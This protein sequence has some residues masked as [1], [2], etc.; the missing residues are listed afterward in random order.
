[1]DHN[2]ISDTI[3]QSMTPV[4]QF[5]DE[6]PSAMYV[7][8]FPCSSFRNEEPSLFH[9]L[10]YDKCIP[11]EILKTL[12]LS[13]SRDCIGGSGFQSL[14]A[15]D[16]NSN[17]QGANEQTARVEDVL[18]N[19]EGPKFRSFIEPL[20]KRETKLKKVQEYLDAASIAGYRL[21][22]FFYEDIP[23]TICLK[24]A[25][26]FYHKN[27]KPEK[28]TGSGESQNR[29]NRELK[30][31]LIETN[32]TESSMISE[33]YSVVTKKQLRQEFID[34][35][36]VFSPERFI[37]GV[38]EMEI[39]RRQTDLNTYFDLMASGG[40]VDG[41]SIKR[42]FFQKDL[43]FEV[44]TSA[45]SKIMGLPL[46]RI[47]TFDV[48]KLNERLKLETEKSKKIYD[49]QTRFVSNPNVEFFKS[50]FSS[51]LTK[52]GIGSNHTTIDEFVNAFRNVITEVE[53]T[54]KTTRALMEDCVVSLYF[55]ESSKAIEVF[56]EQKAILKIEPLLN[57]RLKYHISFSNLRNKASGMSYEQY[58][59]EYNLIKK[60]AQHE[61]EITLK[62]KNNAQPVLKAYS[63][64]T[65]KKEPF[66]TNEREVVYSNLSRFGNMIVWL[67][68]VFS[69]YFS[70]GANTMAYLLVFLSHRVCFTFKPYG[71][72]VNVFLTGDT[73]VG[74]TKLVINL[75]SISLGTI[76]IVSKRTNSAAHTEG[77]HPDAMST[78]FH[79]EI[80][81]SLIMPGSS[82]KSSS[83]TKHEDAKRIM[84]M[85]FT[86]TLSFEYEEDP[87]TGK[88]VRTAR[89][90]ATINSNNSIFGGNIM[91]FAGSRVNI[92]K[93]SPFLSRCLSV[94]LVNSDASPD[95]KK[96]DR[97]YPNILDKDEE[98][99]NKDD[100]IKSETIHILIEAAITAGAIED[101][102]MYIPNLVFW[103]VFERL[104]NHGYQH[105]SD[106]KKIYYMD[107][108]RTLT[109][110]YVVDLVYFSEL[111]W[112]SRQ[113][114]EGKTK[115][116]EIKSIFEF[117]E[118]LLYC[119]LEIA[120]FVLTMMKEQLIDCSDLK[121]VNAIFSK[122]TD[123]WPVKG[124]KNEHKINWAKKN[125]NY[126]NDNEPDYNYIVYEGKDYN[127]IVNSLRS[128]TGDLSS[129]HIKITLN[130]LNNTYIKSSKVWKQLS[131][132][133]F[134][135][136]GVNNTTNT[137]NTN[138]SKECKIKEERKEEKPKTQKKTVFNADPDE[139]FSDNDI[140]CKENDE[141]E[142]D[143]K[144]DTIHNEDTM[145][146][147]VDDLD[148]MTIRKKQSGCDMCECSGYMQSKVEKKCVRCSH[149]KENHFEKKQCNT[150]EK[151]D[152]IDKRF[153][154]PKCKKF[155][156]SSGWKCKTT[157]C[158]ECR[159]ELHEGCPFNVKCKTCGLEM[160]EED[161]Y[162]H[163][164]LVETQGE[165]TGHNAVRIFRDKQ[166]GTTKLLLST[167][168]IDFSKMAIFD[169][170]VRSLGHKHLVGDMD[171]VCADFLQCSF[172]K[173]GGG[174]VHTFP[175][176]CSTIKLRKEDR[177][178]II[179]NFYRMNA[180][181][182][183]VLSRSDKTTSK[184][185]EE[186]KNRIS[187]LYDEAFFRLDTDLDTDVYVK[188]LKKLMLLDPKK[189]VNDLEVEMLWGIPYF[190]KKLIERFKQRQHPHEEEVVL[191]GKMEVDQDLPTKTKRKD[192]I[193]PDYLIESL[194]KDHEKLEAKVIEELKSYKES[195]TLFESVSNSS[196]H[197]FEGMNNGGLLVD[198]LTQS[199]DA[200]IDRFTPRMIKKMKR[201]ASSSATLY[202]TFNK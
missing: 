17:E 155:F 24:N 49:L 82:D 58:K 120:S 130:T 162:E 157:T 142:Q 188:R 12:A 166:T 5:P 15:R 191:P 168:A 45:F 11:R 105:P 182:S 52:Y 84:T 141:K 81:R 118:P 38:S 160:H 25:H 99:I 92:E 80:P 121:I 21:W 101:V 74:K 85:P 123:A 39:D 4:D 2:G 33:L 18:F 19:S 28:K 114:E 149:T 100:I 181:S 196:N 190:C 69:Q 200:I 175:E 135:Y 89:Y 98:E 104:S 30:N 55:R 64:V 34:F 61:F 154:C 193:Y 72:K 126:N 70:S 173:D 192:H 47:E 171:I 198:T 128:I 97:M 16:F 6:I 139:L 77:Q 107:L 146:I 44:S 91:D 79:D 151:I 29:K 102:D 108:C 148:L 153:E 170:A 43:L 109:I 42:N 50:K 197:F 93:N 199:G 185:D 65:N 159:Y 127:S 176:Y 194:R 111:G 35:Q 14:S 57:N 124:R 87:E 37:S 7:Y 103:L 75:A 67:L 117:V 20:I 8:S 186:R 48:I 36:R 9:Q 131:E 184:G 150:C 161:M 3:I 66:F 145:D 54:I 56:D 147:L 132:D 165:G 23:L 1:M 152:F 115:P 88:R 195:S 156:C 26:A 174:K 163:E 179:P 129:D 46:P 53:N 32:N 106:R 164:D 140:D 167:S 177:E 183:L 96:S 62:N 94:P 51:D 137:T 59:R 169:E 180:H 68:S 202:S 13:L 187:E 90:S 27:I 144:K 133:N 116:F 201:E 40:S 134:E 76:K 22:I 73:S 110:Q 158:I 122:I 71:I 125:S 143:T 10:K 95:K 31:D 41:N 189:G 78:V 113:T 138:S 63:T 83:D 172:R 136:I 112:R 86:S 119:P 178:L 60:S